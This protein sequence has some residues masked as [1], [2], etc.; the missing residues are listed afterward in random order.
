MTTDLYGPAAGTWAPTSE[1]L[2][3]TLVRTCE[4]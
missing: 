2:H 1:P 4:P 3:R